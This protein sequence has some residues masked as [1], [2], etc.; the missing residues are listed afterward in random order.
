MDVV[1]TPLGVIKY[2]LITDIIHTV[3]MR[4]VFQKIVLISRMFLKPA[5]TVIHEHRNTCNFL[6]YKAS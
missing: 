6:V 3:D 2:V 4:A 1:K 5:S